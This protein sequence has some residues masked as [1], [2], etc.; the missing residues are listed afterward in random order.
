[1]GSHYNPSNRTDN[2]GFCAIA[3]ALHLQKHIE[4]DADR[5]YLQTLQRLGL[6][7]DAGK[8]P[9]PRMLIFPDP[10]LDSAAVRIEYSAL[11]GGTHGLSSYTITSVAEANGLR[12]Q[13]KIKDLELPRQFMTYYSNVRSGPW[14]IGDFEQMRLNFLRSRGSNPKAED[15]KKYIANELGGHSILGSKV[16]KH[17]INVFIDIGRTGRIEAFDAQ[18]GAKYDGVGLNS[19]LGSVDLLMHLL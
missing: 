16:R 18:D 17:Y 5:L 13:A 1:M 19:R 4:V 2:C 6:T 12:F 7:R 11:T 14:S 9:I 10:M 3:Y 8:D 15:V